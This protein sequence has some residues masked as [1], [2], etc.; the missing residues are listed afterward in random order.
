[1]FSKVKLKVKLLGAF[2]IVS[3]IPM[4]LVAFIALNNAGKS[5]SNEA[6]AKFTA[7]QETKRNHLEDHFKYLRT[8]MRAIKGDPFLHDAFMLFN[9]NFEEGG[10]TVVNN[11]FWSYYVEEKEPRIKGIVEENGFFD[12]YLISSKGNIIYSA[13]KESDLG[14]NIPGTKLAD[15]NLGKAYKL[16]QEAENNDVVLCD[17]E[18]YAP[19]K[20][21]PAAFMMAKMIDDKNIFIGFVAIRLSTAQING[22]VQQ[23]SGMGKTGESF[24]VGKL[25]GKTFLRSDLTFKKGKINDIVSHEYANLAAS[26]KSSSGIKEG[27]SGIKEFV[28]YDSLNIKGLDWGMI[29][30]AS[31]DEVFGA[32][33]VLRNS[34]FMIILVV[35]FCVIAVALGV[36]SIIVKPI[37][38]TARMFKDIAEGEGDLTKRLE[39]NTQDEI[40]EMADSFNTFMEN[41]QGIIQQ[42]SDDAITLNGASSSLSS[43]AG[44]MTGGVSKV[45]QSSEQVAAATE[46]M[47]VTMN[48]V[49]AA[50]EQAS[51]N[52]NNM[53]TSA[54]EM[55]AT[56]NEIAQNSENARVVSETAVVKAA[57]TSDKID[58]LGLS[59]NKISKVTEVIS[60]IS[61]LTNLLA[62]NATIEA[63]RAGEAGKGFAVVANE[64]K[65]LAKQTASATMEINGLINGIQGST[66]DTINQ[67]QEITKVVNEVNEFV[68]TI[69]TA[70]EEQSATSNEIANNVSQAS[71]GIQEI[72]ENVNQSSTVAGSIST[73][74][75]QVNLSVQEIAN[76]SGQVNQKA[77]E[78]SGLA[79]KL[80]TLV[81]RFKI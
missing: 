56:M 22:I 55:T 3:L 40:G 31:T 49:A 25:H 54:E 59:V 12:F 57:D 10:N 21:V 68:A 41:L 2:L 24:L 13:K 5:L 72:N 32:V 47:S 53:A 23:R 8:T 35:I 26:G 74:I 77:D 52:V 43:I 44:Q 76:S 15:T 30:A 18:P 67:I 33:G 4:G 1:M 66:K 62:L 80:K 79:E 71:L 46:E 64:I 73:D 69:A 37:N 61:E 70:I 48:S 39:V 34:L 11:E 63:A 14:L 17:F 20:G 28:R 9:S 42:I 58:H 45:S 65:E 78:L 6:V 29:T 38:N 27:A 19:S 50:S 51:T 81:D 75:S 7:I 36:T 60:E 16:I